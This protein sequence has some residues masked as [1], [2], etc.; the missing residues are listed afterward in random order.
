VGRAF[1]GLAAAAA[2]LL[3]AM[4]VKLVQPLRGRWLA[5]GIACLAFLALALLK[6]PLLWT[7]LVLTPISVLLSYRQGL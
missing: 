3:V 6:L 1:A 2:G 5:L 4:A 7:M